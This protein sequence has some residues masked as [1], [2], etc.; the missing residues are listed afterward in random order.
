MPD[1]QPVYN[2]SYALVM[3]IDGY[4]YLPPLSAAVQGAQDLAE[5]LECQLHFETTLFTDSDVT[6]D[7]I[8]NWLTTTR[9]TAGPDD[10]VIVYFSGH[11]MTRG[12]A[13][14]ERGYFALS[15]SVPDEWHTA[16]PMD[17]II[18][19]AGYFKAKHLLYLLDCCFGGLALVNKAAPDIPRELEY[20]ISR[21]V[22]Y[23]ISA[24]G[25]EVVDDSLGPGG[26]HSLFTYHLLDWLRG[27]E[28]A[29]ASGI[30]RAR[31][32]GNYLEQV[33]AHDRRSGHKPNHN[34]LPGSGDGDFVF[35]WEAGTRLPTDVQLALASPSA[36]LRQGAVVQLI[37]LACGEDEA[38][39]ALAQERLQVIACGDP[40]PQV[41]QAAQS[42]FDEQEALAQQR[43]DKIRRAKA[44]AQ[45]QEAHRR[46]EE[47]ERAL[48]EAEKEQQKL[49]EADRARQAALERARQERVI[50]PAAGR[51][52]PRAEAA[53]TP[54][55]AA[56]V[57]APLA[58]TAAPSLERVPSE[59]GL[60]GQGWGIRALARVIDI[61]LIDVVIYGA[62]IVAL[63]LY[64][65]TTSGYDTVYLDRIL[66]EAGTCLYLAGIV[67]STGYF[68]VCQSFHGSTLGK[69]MCGLVVVNDDGARAGLKANVVRELGYLI[70]SLILGL[71]AAAAMRQSPL[72]QRLGDRWAHTLVVKRSQVKPEN[73]SGGGTFV[74]IFLSACIFVA[75]FGA[76]VPVVLML[77][78]W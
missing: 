28:G 69:L 27:Q 50:A 24:G 35:R 37:E 36:Y 70:D 31:E 9:R 72:K 47:A 57:V 76:L 14:H 44:E 13:V 63:F 23:A 30:W 41:R 67:A 2:R 65:I 68:V 4:R 55:T 66:T 34:Y 40:D 48:R 43:E 1:Y 64:E 62:Y 20:Y 6:R 19:E 21:P 11:G 56:E 38:L 33:V 8:F 7:S 74:A 5:F 75:V 3:G 58:P 54:V 10:R 42:Y 17:D 52:K 12:D 22:R 49:A 78:S 25:K 46:Q 77:I 53:S 71:I 29:P 51:V 61:I 15:E 32:L 60:I 26:R 59:G 16:V 73:R 39:A 45:M 18:D